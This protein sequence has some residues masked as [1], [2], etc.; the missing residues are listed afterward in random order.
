MTTLTWDDDEEP[1]PPL[2]EDDEPWDEEEDGD[3]ELDWDDL[4]PSTSEDLE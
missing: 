3:L 2:D 1:L 4:E